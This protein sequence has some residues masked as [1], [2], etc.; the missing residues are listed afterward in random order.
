MTRLA[1]T[2]LLVCIASVFA[3]DAAMNKPETFDQNK[4]WEKAKSLHE[5]HANDIHGNDVSLDKYRG[6]VVL[7]VNVASKCGLTDSN[8]KQLQKLY[9]EYQGKGL[10]I[11][12]FP[13][14]DFNQ[15][16]G[17]ADEILE[18]VKQY[19]VTFDMM[20]KIHVN[21]DEAHPLYKWLKSQEAGK[22]IFGNS[23]KW[24]FSKFLVDKSGKVVDRFAPT[25]EPESFE[26]TIVEYLNKE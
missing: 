22:G 16:P 5:F 2:L 3:E 7:V 9:N 26:K 20:E 17:T 15:E 21:G 8:Y 25:T 23:I 12:A 1:I 24:N 11:L 18:F 14:N 13:S 19:G 4:D 6:N 10:Q